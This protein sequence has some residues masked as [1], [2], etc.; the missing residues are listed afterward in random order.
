[1]SVENSTLKADVKGDYDGVI[2][3]IS[4]LELSGT[5]DNTRTDYVKV[6]KVTVS[7]NN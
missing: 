7:L 2:S 3:V 6:G 1:M 4:K 5:L